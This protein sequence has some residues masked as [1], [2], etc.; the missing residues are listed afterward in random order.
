MKK[1]FTAM[2]EFG[3]VQVFGRRDGG[4]VHALGG[5]RPKTCTG[6]VALKLG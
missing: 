6:A 1:Q 5:R 4:T 3:S 2:H